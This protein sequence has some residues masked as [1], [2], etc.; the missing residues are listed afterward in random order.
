MQQ[1]EIMKKVLILAQMLL[2]MIHLSA[3]DTSML[4]SVIKEHSNY[5][6]GLCKHLHQNPELSF[7]EFNTSNRMAEELKLIGFEVTT[8]VG[9][10]S[11]VGVYENGEGP[12]ILIRTD[13]DA[14]PIR[15]ETGFP[16]SSKVE[17]ENHKG[18][19]SS[20][21]HACGHDVHMSVFIGSLR[22][23]IEIKNQWKGKLLVIAQQ[24]EEMGAG[25]LLALN[26]G[27][28]NK[29]GVPDYGLAFHIN[30]F[31]ES[32]K[33][34]L[35]SGPVFAGVKTMEITVKG[36]GGHGA[37]PEKY[38]DPIV[39]A[40]RIVTDLQSVVSREISP[41]QP[42]VVTVGSIH[43]G[44][45]HNII[46][47]EVKLQLTL[48]Y[49][50]EATIHQVITA[51]KR[52]CKGA[53]IAAGVPEEKMPEFWIDENEV[54]PV[55]NHDKLSNRLANNLLQIKGEGF[56]SPVEPA[57]VGE[58][59][60]NYG[61]TKENVPICLIWLGATSS[62]EMNR[63]RMIGEEP[64]PLHSAKLNPDYKLT[65]QTGIEVM[66]NNVLYLCK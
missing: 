52:K 63:L 46:P 60:G 23:L 2:Q 32:G 45:T 43:G 9:G 1:D 34:A 48:R 62:A 10:N 3:Q 7:M 65:I 31:V 38:V 8:G 53:A 61:K 12:T 64:A 4:Q 49:Y 21:M 40:S 19:M 56:N 54:P 26:D 17:M 27:L 30:P 33:I 25:A 16:F 50:E 14:L 35:S 28:Y 57:M 36:I 51:I 39:L 44:T 42:V 5:A 37:Y 29:F 22:S 47:D 55:L 58:D 59:F 11:V 13:M 20:V 15:E 18:V 24:A 41:Q 6:F 66:V